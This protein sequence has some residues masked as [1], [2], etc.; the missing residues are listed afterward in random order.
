MGKSALDHAWHLLHGPCLEI[1]FDDFRARQLQDMHCASR[2]VDL[3]VTEV[4]SGLAGSYAAKVAKLV[5]LYVVHCSDC[6]LFLL[7]WY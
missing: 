2:V 6:L 1:E 5:L 7:K 4:D 3:F